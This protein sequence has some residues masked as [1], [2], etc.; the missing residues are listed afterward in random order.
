V[1]AQELGGQMM[2]L[3][4]RIFQRQGFRGFVQ[5]DVGGELGHDLKSVLKR[6]V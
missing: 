1:H 3:A 5:F 4:G 2:F 6:K